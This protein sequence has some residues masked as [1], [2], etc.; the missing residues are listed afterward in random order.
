MK[1]YRELVVWQ[2][3]FSLA[4][5]CYSI[6]GTFPKNQQ[7]S[8]VQQIQRAAV[9]IPSNIAEGYNRQSRKE[10][11]QFLHIAFG[12]IA[13]LETQL[14]IAREQG[15]IDDR[16]LEQLATAIIE[17]SKMLRRMIEKLKAPKP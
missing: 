12:S 5:T 1:S 7:F 6:T 3:A 9:S 16:M 14:L 15:Y 10:Y 11:V 4:N 2:K 8:L 17:I 13:E